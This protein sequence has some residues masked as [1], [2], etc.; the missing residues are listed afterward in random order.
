MFT[1]AGILAD[2][3][4]KTAVSASGLYNSSSPNTSDPSYTYSSNLLSGRSEFSI[5]VWAYVDSSAQSNFNLKPY[6]ESS[7][8]TQNIK[9]IIIKETSV[10]CVI[11]NSNGGI[12]TV[13]STTANNKGSFIHLC[14]TGSVSNNRI[15]IYRNGT[16]LSSAVMTYANATST[17]AITFST[18]LIDLAQLNIYD[19]ELPEEE[20]SEHYVYDSD[21]S[22]AGVLGYDAMTTSQRSGL[23]YSSSFIDSI[24]F[25]GNEFKDRSGN[26]ISLS[27]NPP[28]TG[29][30]IYVYTDA[31]DLPSDEPNAFAPS[32]ATLD[33]STQYLRL[34]SDSSALD[35]GTDVLSISGWV[36]VDSNFRYLY[37]K[38][39]GSSSYARVSAYV[40]GD[41]QKFEFNAEQGG[42][43]L[44]ISAD[45]PLSTGWRHIA[46]TWT[47]L[48][49]TDTGTLFIDGVEYT[50]TWTARVANGSPQ[51]YN[52]SVA[53]AFTL[54]FL[55]LNFFTG[56]DH[57]GTFIGVGIGSELTQADATYLY[58]EGDILCWGDVESDN[59][60][61]YNKFTE[62]WD[63]ATY[64]GSSDTDART[65]KK[66]GYVLD[67]V[68]S[69]TYEPTGA[70]IV[71][72][73]GV[74]Y[75]ASYATLDGSDKLTADTT[76]SGL[77]TSDYSIQAKFKTTMSGFAFLLTQFK[78][79][80]DTNGAWAIAISS[81]KLRIEHRTTT[82]SNNYAIVETTNTYNDGEWH[83]VIGFV[84]QTNQ[85]IHIIID[86]VNVALD[87]LA[88]AG[89]PWTG[90]TTK[91]TYTVGDRDA[92]SSPYTGE[93]AS[94][95][96]AL[97]DLRTVSS[98]I[99][100]SS[101]TFTCWNDYSTSTQAMYLRHQDLA[102][103][104]GSSETDAQTDNVG[105]FS[106]LTNS[107]ATYESELAV[108]CDEDPV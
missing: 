63:L 15:R 82:F 40:R 103:F 57:T 78:P 62:V 50:G 102:T 96:L 39:E 37:Y 43:D 6:L 75:N 68:N 25:S 27:I 56:Y 22:Q 84:D 104:N 9:P 47:R 42:N 79:S 97:G 5:M 33:G 14:V 29:Q 10:E 36:H 59:P 72:D 28:L 92:F 53:T 23:L 101:D 86:G 83:D 4:P 19:R 38:E 3:E 77:G 41:D 54:G 106:N 66:A 45:T 58:N 31:S 105:T 99:F 76:D 95:G 52:Y 61:L 64:N 74:Q 65:G 51:N 11:S 70:L 18:S 17:E 26:D 1:I 89:S 13:G 108:E 88:T 49:N 107:G 35:I 80:D 20:V 69:P 67:K 2:E 85:N 81:G 87:A 34:N 100:P 98:E 12:T 24:S 30:Q 73:G 90:I 46:Y 60:T 94:V 16:L 44:L 21:T 91:G 8:V 93:I 48:S 71:S 32:V 55:D 7:G